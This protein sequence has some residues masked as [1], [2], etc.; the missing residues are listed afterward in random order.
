[1]TD[2][3][4]A[5]AKQKEE[6]KGL[7]NDSK[8]HTAVRNSLNSSQQEAIITNYFSKEHQLCKNSKAICEVL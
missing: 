4:S 2:T 5:D 1:V 6:K 8:I 7:E 3:I